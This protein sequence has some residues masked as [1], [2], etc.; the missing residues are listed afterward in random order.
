MKS[1][2]V[3][4]YVA[5]LVLQ[6]QLVNNRVCG[7]SSTNNL[8]FRQCRVHGTRIHSFSLIPQI[9]SRQ[10]KT[11]HL[12]VFEPCDCRKYGGARYICVRM[13]NKRSDLGESNDERDRSWMN[14]IKDRLRNNEGKQ[15]ED[16]TENEDSIN[17]PTSLERMRT[18]V[19][20]FFIRSNTEQSIAEGQSDPQPKGIAKGGTKFD[21]TNRLSK[22]IRVEPKR[23]IEEKADQKGKARVEQKINQEKEKVPSL[24]TKKAT[25]F[26]ISQ[27]KRRDKNV[28]TEYSKKKTDNIIAKEKSMFSFIPKIQIM[29]E[30]EY[31]EDDQGKDNSF[32]NMLSTSLSRATDS[33]VSGFKG[34]FGRITNDLSSMIN[35]GDSITV[36]RKN[37]DKDEWYVGCPKTRI[38]PG[39]A[40]PVVVAGLDLLLIASNDA[41]SIYCVANQCPHL[42]TPLET[43][44]IEQREITS[45]SSSTRNIGGTQSGLTYSGATRSQNSEDCIVCPLHRTAFSLQTG[46]VRGEWTPYPPVIGK[47]MGAVKSES[48]LPTF[49]V[50]ARGKNIEVRLSSSLENDEDKTNIIR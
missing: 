34:Y 42:G 11:R 9:T 8:S 49:P 5:W 13:A 2:I 3:H 26:E 43:G 46:E 4:S 37:K 18:R 41:K 7:F 32:P 31:N 33:A 20:S 12:F 28:E 1:V 45:K 44:K 17:S 29:R 14:R 24:T 27:G 48:N 22:P 23:I 35:M 39:E 30:A 16:R 19:T 36:G 6:P 47:V 10:R 50:R 15:L 38:S 21:F 25:S 40:V